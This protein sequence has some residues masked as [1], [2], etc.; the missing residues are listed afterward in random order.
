MAGWVIGIIGGS[1]LYALDALVGMVTDNDCWRE[2][3]A[4]VE[5]STEVARLNANADTARRMVEALSRALPAER[6]SSPIDT[7]LDGAIL[8]APS[9]RDPAMLARLDAIGKRRFAAERP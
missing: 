5:A 2:D 4:P 9:A 7:I 1:G 8:T 6:T 3:E